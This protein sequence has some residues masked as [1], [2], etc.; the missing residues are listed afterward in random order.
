M[1][2]KPPLTHLCPLWCCLNGLVVSCLTINSFLPIR[3]VGIMVILFSMAIFLC[4]GEVPCDAV[5][6]SRRSSSFV[7]FPF[8][9]FPLEPSITFRSLLFSC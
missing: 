1:G 3:G 6:I 2:E 4:Y 7:N 8:A 9:K 5:V